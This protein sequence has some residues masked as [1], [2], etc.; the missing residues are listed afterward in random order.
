MNRLQFPGSGSI[1]LVLLMV[2]CWVCWGQAAEHPPQQAAP[3]GQQIDGVVIYDHDSAT[4]L[5]D[6]VS[7]NIICDF[8]KDAP[9]RNS[10]GGPVCI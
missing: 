10:H 6:D 9:G 2:L 7:G 5:G 4:K 3:S 8:E 1:E